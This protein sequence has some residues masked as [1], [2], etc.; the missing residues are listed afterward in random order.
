MREEDRPP[1]ALWL[2]EEAMTE[3]FKRVTERYAGGSGME[4]IEPMEQNALTKS[5]MKKRR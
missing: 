5:L 2:D 3:H 1:E 4:P